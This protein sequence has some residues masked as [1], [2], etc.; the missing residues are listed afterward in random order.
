VNRQPQGLVERFYELMPVTSRIPADPDTGSVI[1]SYERRL[2]TDLDTVVGT[3]REPLDGN[4][5]RLRAAETNLGDL[6]ADAIRA[7]ADTDIAIMNAGRIRADRVYPAG[8]LSRRTLLAIHPFANVITKTAV[9]GRVIL[10]A[11]NSGVSRLPA[12]AG[13]FPQVSGLT[14]VIDPNAPAGDRV[15]D[16]RIGGQPLQPDKTYTVAIPDLVLKGG[17]GFTMF[18]GHPVLVGPE[19]GNLLVGALEKYVAG[20]GEI[21]PRVDGRITIRLTA[22]RQPATK[23]AITARR[24]TRA[25]AARRPAPLTRGRARAA[26]DL[27]SCRRRSCRRRDAP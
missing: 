20:K 10:D 3:T 26:A 27:R 8:P 23:A 19:A 4:S 11:V 15:R 7:D 18:A 6:V 22:G 13:Q 1:E 25:R 17:D 21:R 24:T 5:V 2:G 9:P 12:S 14:M 16:V